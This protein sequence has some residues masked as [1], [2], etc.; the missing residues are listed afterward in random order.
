MFVAS[1]ARLQ[2]IV[3]P[4]KVYIVHSVREAGARFARPGLCSSCA[5]KHIVDEKQEN[6]REQKAIHALRR[7]LQLSPDLLPAWL[8]LAVSHTND[9]DRQ[10]AYT[11]VREW[12]ARNDRYAAAVQAYEARR[13]MSEDATQ[14]ER[15]NDLI[16]CLIDMAR[17]DASGEVDADIQVALAILMNT[18]EVRTTCGR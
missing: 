7:A 6:E 9:G 17:S 12:V 2:C 5:N 15:F 10:G 18:N 3:R 11:A 16:E 8:A 14:A 4:S 1:L 13:G